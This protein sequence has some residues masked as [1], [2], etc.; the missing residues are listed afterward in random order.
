MIK[1]FNKKNKF[2][3]AALLL[4][5]ALTAVGCVSIEQV[6]EKD[7]T[8]V[9]SDMGT[10]NAA[11]SLSVTQ[12]I[13]ENHDAYAKYLPRPEFN[14]M[15]EDYEGEFGGIGIYMGFY[16]DEPYPV[17]M[18][19]MEG[20]PAELAGVVAGD[21]IITVNGADMAGVESDKVSSAVRGAVGTTVELTL[22]GEDGK[23]RTVSIKRKIIH[24]VTVRSTEITGHPEIAYISILSFSESTPNDFLDIFNK[25]NLEHLRSAMIIDLR[26]NGGGSFPASLRIAGFFVPKGNTLVWVKTSDGLANEVSGGKLINLPVICLQNGG[27]ASASEV[28]LGA[29]IDNDC[30]V[31]V[32]TQ[33]Y[34]KGITQSVSPLL[35]SAGI[36]YTNGKYFTPDMTDLHGVGLSPTHEVSL[37][38]DATGADIGN[39]EI[40]NQLAKAISLLTEQLNK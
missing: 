35:S 20:E 6:S 17:I 7:N 22:E 16:P 12:Y 21:K 24:S 40:D 9:I 39:P 36:R 37:N 33:S 15:I 34:G 19:V 29:L 25:L 30:A 38:E 13:S 5:A 27:S 23:H 3:I 8:V 26:G 32:G 31:S 28:L 1:F 10:I 4:M 11:L 2:L 18:D 14:K